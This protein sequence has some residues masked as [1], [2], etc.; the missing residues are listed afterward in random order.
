[1]RII[2]AFLRDLWALTRP[3]WF[4]EERWSAR[5]LLAVIVSFNLGLVYLEVLF[6]RWQNHFY[7]SLQNRDI[8]AFYELLLYFSFLAAVFIAV[9]VYQSYLNQMLQI[10]WRRWLTEKYFVAWIANRTYYRMQLTDGGTD[11]PDQRIADDLAMFVDRTLNLSLGFLSAVVTL[12]SF[13]AILWALSGALEVT[14]AGAAVRVEGYMVWVALVYAIFGTWLAHVIGRPLARLNFNQQRLE[15]NFRFSLVRFR[16]NAESIAI[17]RGEAD[18]IRSLRRR[19]LDVVGNWW[20]IMLRQK[21]LNWFRTGYSQVAIIFPYLVAAPRYFSG[22]IQ[23]GG[24]MQTASA[25]GQVQGALS[26]FI[27]AYAQLADWKATVDRLTGFLAAT[28]RARVAS[29]DHPGIITDIKDGAVRVEQLRLDLPDG[30]PLLAPFN[31]SISE[32]EK[33]L[34]TGPSGS[35]KS[36]LFRALAGIWPFGVGT[37]RRPASRVLFLPQKPYLTVGTLREQVSYPAAPGTFDDASCRAAL[38]DCGLPH[39]AD[40]LDEEQHWAQRLSGGEQ[41]RIAFARALLHRPQWLF[42]DEATSSLDEASETRMHRLLQEC[43]PHATVISIGHRPSLAAFHERRMRIE[44]EPG[45]VGRVVL[46]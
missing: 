27:T 20:A 19:F 33:V 46:A 1:M 15:A 9:S 35:G 14:F 24:L 18:E 17:Y 8:N 12:F 40:R 22:Q 11:N 21:K 41:Q 39:L 37:V 2:A 31:A 23:L 7:N 34:V 13:L 30:A 4:S 29:G 45:G 44:R 10:R 26:W 42:L 16:E 3:Y 6:N 25:F 28:E 38:M 43:M 5:A 36:T 32:G